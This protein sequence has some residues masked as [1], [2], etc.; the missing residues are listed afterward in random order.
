MKKGTC[1][2]IFF[3]EVGKIT[4]NLCRCGKYRGIK[5][6]SG[7]NYDYDRGCLM[8]DFFSFECKICRFVGFFSYF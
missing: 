6:E 2:S 5:K 3:F 8:N 4:Q 7:K 1:F